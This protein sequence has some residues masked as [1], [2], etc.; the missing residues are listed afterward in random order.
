MDLRYDLARY[1]VRDVASFVGMNDETLRRWVNRGD[2]ISSLTP[3]TPRGAS[4]P[5]VAVAEVQFFSHLRG[6]GLSLRAITEGMAAVRDALGP[7]MLQEGRLAHDGRDTLVDLHDDEAA[8]EWERARDRQGGIRGIIE[9]ALVPITWAEDGLPARVALDR[10]AG[11]EVVVDHTVAFGRPILTGLGVRVEDVVEMWLAGDSIETVS[12][13][14]GVSREL[15]ESL[16]RGYA[17]AA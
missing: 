15:V 14:F 10:Y 13:E 3:E 5:F 9:N 11:A 2:L 1:T 17:Q 4:L 6:Q 8:V 12:R 7:R 16:A